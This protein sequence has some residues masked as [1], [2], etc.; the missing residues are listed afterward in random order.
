MG[1]AAHAVRMTQR[2]QPAGTSPELVQS[3]RLQPQYRFEARSTSLKSHPVEAGAPSP[4]ELLEYQRDLYE[5]TILLWDAMLKRMGTSCPEG[6]NDIGDRV[7]GNGRQ[8]RSP[9]S[10]HEKVARQA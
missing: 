5:R 10:V 2:R 8:F 6:A 1:S 3:A 9:E 4:Q 7:A